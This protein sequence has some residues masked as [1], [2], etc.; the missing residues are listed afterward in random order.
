MVDSG[1]GASLNVNVKSRVSFRRS[2]TRI[3]LL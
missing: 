3:T 2:K 1:G